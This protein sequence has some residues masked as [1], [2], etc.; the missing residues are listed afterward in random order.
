MLRPG[1]QERAA[2]DYSIKTYNAAQP[3]PFA[4]MCDRLAEELTQ[5]LPGATARV[6][7]GGPVWFLEDNPVAGYWLRKTGL[8]LLFWS[9]Q[10]FDAP[11]L[12]PE[13]KFK[14]AEVV[15][16]ATDPVDPVALRGWLAK[17]VLIQWD[18]KN[19]VK[20]KGRLEKLGDW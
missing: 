11:G 16:T 20:R 17:A 5:G 4:A 2:M 7:H 14:A 18:Y 15:F 12:K 6:W 9:G 13:G 19:I 3:A 8:Q 10:S 1:S